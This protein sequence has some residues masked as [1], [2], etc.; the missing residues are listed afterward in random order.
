MQNIHDININFDENT[1]GLII[2]KSQYID[3]AYIQ[4]LKDQRFGSKTAQTGEY[5]RA[6]SIPVVIV[7]KWMKEGYDVFSEPIRKTVAKLKAEGLDYFVTTDKQ[8]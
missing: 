8:I 3:P 4:G 1:E 6:A 5:M 2:E 7:E